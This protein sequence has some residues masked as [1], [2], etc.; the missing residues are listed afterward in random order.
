MILL[1]QEKYG[2]ITQL[3]FL[4]Y[5]R[6]VITRLATLGPPLELGMRLVRRLRHRLFRI[7]E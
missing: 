1:P 2:G 3:T 5:P 6:V 4:A 7:P